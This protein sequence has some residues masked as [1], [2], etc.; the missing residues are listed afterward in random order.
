MNNYKLYVH[1][2]PNGK[3]YYG[4]TKQ[5]PKRRWLSGAGY[6]N[7]QYF[8]RAINKY[9]WDNIEHI[10]LFDSLTEHEAKELEQYM[11]QWYNTA[12]YKYGYNQSLGGDGGYSGYKLSEET[13]RKK[14]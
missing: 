1:I 8:F 11:I 14:S 7:N 3:R 12:N 6:R 10:V 2:C 4:I 9:G 5:E 13:K